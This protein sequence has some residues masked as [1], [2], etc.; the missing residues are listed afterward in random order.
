MHTF[1]VPAEHYCHYTV[2]TQLTAEGSADDL[3]GSPLYSAC[4]NAHVIC[5]ST[6]HV[7][8]ANLSRLPDACGTACR[9]V[10]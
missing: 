2:A 7:G 6:H 1:L 3:H 9:H 8:G 10:E 5:R 4:M